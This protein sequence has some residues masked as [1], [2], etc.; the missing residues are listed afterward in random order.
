MPEAKGQTR[1][2]LQPLTSGIIRTAE[3]E[4]KGLA[5]FAADCGV[6]YDSA[7]CSTGAILRMHNVFTKCGESPFG[8]GYAVIDPDAPDRIARDARRIRERGLVQIC[9]LIDGWSPEAHKYKLGS[10]CL[11]AI[12]SRPGWTVRILTKSTAIFAD[13]DYICRHHARV[14]VGVSLTGA[15]AKADAISAIEPHG[16]TIPD[17]MAIIRELRR[18]GFRAYGMLGPLLPGM[19]DSDKEVRSLVQYVVGCGAEEVFV[20]PV[21]AHCPYL[22]LTQEALANH[23]YAAEAAA[24]AA[25]RN[26]AG[27]SRYVVYLLK[28]VQ[29]AMREFSDIRKLRFLLYPSRLLSEDAA[30]IRAD[31]AGVVWLGKDGRKVSGRL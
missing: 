10:R 15:S 2:H 22:R 18:W 24:V 3:L 28:N 30:A 13:W 12:L 25:I 20:E 17:R 29:A 26:Q 16:A 23:G 19:A 6:N 7:H 31:D 8:F 5:T 11:R 14:L 27:W 4:R 21:T 1:V 9:P